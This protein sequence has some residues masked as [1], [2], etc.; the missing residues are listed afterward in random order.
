MKLL[1]LTLMMIVFCK[2]EQL[3]A[4]ALQIDKEVAN[5][6]KRGKY[7]VPALVDDKTFLRRAFLVSV[8]RIPTPR[9]SLD[10]IELDHPDKRKLLAKYLYQSEGYD[11]HMMN[12]LMDLLTIR[13]EYDAGPYNLN[14]D[15]LSHWVRDAVA[16]NM[17]WDE[18]CERLIATKGNVYVSDGASGY[19]S[20]GDAIDDHLSNTLRI[21]TGIRMECAQCHDDP[22]QEWERIDFYQFK[23]FVSG[24]TKFRNKHMFKQAKKT[25]APVALKTPEKYINGPSG[26][27]MK[28]DEAIQKLVIHGVH[29]TKGAGRVKLPKN[30]QYDDATPGEMVGGR[31]AFGA[32]LKTGD[33]QNDP[34]ALRK[35]AEW[36]TSDATPQFAV[37]IA[38]RMWERVMGISL[39]P[40]TGD[41]IHP[42]DTP[43]EQLILTLAEVMKQCDYDLRMFQQVLMRTQTF[44]FE[45]SGEVLA[46]GSERA[47]LG[48]RVNRMSA[49]QMW[50]SMIS[51]AT[52]NP[53]SLPKIERGSDDFVYGGQTVMTK[54]ELVL[55]VADMSAREYSEFLLSS[56]DKIVAKQYPPFDGN[57]Y[58]GLPPK[59]GKNAYFTMRR[60]SELRSPAR[61]NAFMA[62]FG[63]SGRSAA[64]D[65]A[66]TE[67]TVS[68][69]LEL[70]NGTMQSHIIQRSDSAVNQ[71]LAS[72]DNEEERI[73]CTFLVFLSRN[74][75]AEELQF[76]LNLVRKSQN[77]EATYRNLMSGLMTSQEFYFIH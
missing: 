35:F 3:D 53:E 69:A 5:Y 64:I 55:E 57:K 25:F 71:L 27:I 67:G 49:E 65:E 9:E 8:G 56:F 54:R 18:F 21:F 76:C 32:R 62:V 14:N 4:Y 31:T 72:I 38:N 39:T 19:H 12:W 30:Y 16:D 41:Y 75:D 61:G 28:Y 70:M 60:A 7:Q 73:K 58:V 2:G 46:N 29:E 1:I 26:S 24:S 37:T 51:L 50:D 66:T 77:K 48:R 22:F 43:Y 74:P 13:T 36:M 52:T 47:L 44:R 11:S 40:V 68:Q 23:A 42:K 17:K 20:K 15:R 33:T 63:Q 10:F 34:Q 6:L 45:A 59:R